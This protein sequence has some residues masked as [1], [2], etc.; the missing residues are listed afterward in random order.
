LGVL[1]VC[2]LLVALRWNSLNAPL[3][4]DEGEYAYAAQILQR[5]LHPYQDAFLQKPPMIVYT[6]AAAQAIAP[7]T[8]WFP[9]VLAALFA[10]AAACLLGWIARLEFGPGVAL[11]AMWLVTPMLLAPGLEQFTAN[12][13]MFMVLPLLGAFAV[14]AASRRGWGGAGAWFLAGV[15]G[16]VAFWYKYTVLPVLGVLFA[17]WTFQEWRVWS[18]RFSVS[19]APEGSGHSLKAELQTRAGGKGSSR[20]TFHVSRLASR[21]LLFFLGNCLAS[22]VILAPFLIWDGGR[23]LWQCTVL[24]NRFYS[25]SA[26]FGWSGLLTCTQWF[27]VTWWVLFLLLPVLV[28]RPRPR[29]WFWISAFLVAWVSTGASVF[30]QYYVL[31]MPFWALLA[32]VA[33]KELA[34][35][36]APRLGLPL[37]WVRWAVT[38]A[39]LVLVCVP[40]VP[41]VTCTAQEF[42]AGKAA[43]GNAFLESQAVARH[44]A[45]LTKPSDPVFVAGSEP[46]ILYYANRLS[47]TR[48]VLMYPLLIP[49]PL[50]RGFQAEAIRDLE[51]QPPAAIVFAQSPL[52]WLAQK[53][54]PGEFLEYF[55]KLV[56]AHYERV[57]G[58]V[59]DA[60]GGHWQEP[61]PDQDR[62][63]ASLVL[64]RRN[65]SQATPG[66]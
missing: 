49:T 46:Q 45:Q 8:V 65:S 44:L 18:S 36:V 57:G 31:I 38:A 7:N 3:V 53:D 56:A 43:G 11:P 14:Y 1:G 19:A 60:Q 15:L 52:S 28:F 25:A 32:A 50:A 59:V 29:P 9:R 40:D 12:T 2:A 35:L 30:G 22:L 10:G 54:S 4:R 17:L 51:R 33:I 20:F 61:L 41:W 5:G 42:A 24:F 58:W 26:T 37:P 13:E 34:G 6:Y 27:W 23:A 16:A 63:N 55:D 21:W 48:F 47:S 66:L 39:V 64:F 62:P